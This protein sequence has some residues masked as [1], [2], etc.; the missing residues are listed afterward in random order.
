MEQGVWS[1]VPERTSNLAKSSCAVECDFRQVQCWC[2]EHGCGLQ[3]PT[4]S[5]K[6]EL[7]KEPYTCS[8]N[9]LPDS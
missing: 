6:G 2:F 3:G 1:L 8:P 4:E 9:H 7:G 5:G